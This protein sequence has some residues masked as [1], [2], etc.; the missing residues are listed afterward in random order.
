MVCE[1]IEAG[2]LFIFEKGATNRQH[3]MLSSKQGVDEAVESCAHKCGRV[4]GLWDQMPRFGAS[5][6]KLPL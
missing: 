5:Q 1:P 2:A 4:F 3:E 6:L